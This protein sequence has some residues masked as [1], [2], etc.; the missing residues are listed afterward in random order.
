MGW[1]RTI[2]RVVTT[3]G[4]LVIYW[5]LEPLVSMTTVQGF[6]PSIASSSSGPV[7]G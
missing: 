2:L 1:P 6:E 3:M 5:S 7:W 4:A